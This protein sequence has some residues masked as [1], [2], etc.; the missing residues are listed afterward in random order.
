MLKVVCSGYWKN[1]SK[2]G[3]TEVFC[4]AKLKLDTSWQYV[5][6]LFHAGFIFG[7]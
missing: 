3:K 5:V 7:T 1:L 2:L 4:K 6:G